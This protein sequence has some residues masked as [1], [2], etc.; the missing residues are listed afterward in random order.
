MQHKPLQHVLKSHFVLDPRRTDFIATFVLALIKVRTVNLTQISTA[1]NGLVQPTSN[2]RRSKRF[3]E[4]N[5][6]Q[7]LIAKFVLSFIDDPKLVLTMDRTNWKFGRIS[8]NFLVIGIAFGGIA[9]PV[10]WKNLGKDGNSNQ[11]ERATLLE[12]LLKVIPAHRILALTADREFIGCDW[13]KAL[14]AQEVNPVIRLKS[15]AMI[16]HRGI[17]APASVWFNRLKSG[18]VLELTKARVMGV[19]VFVLA[20]LTPEG[21]F[22]ILATRKRPA[23]AL[24]VYAQRWEIETLF[25]AFKTRG[26]NLEDTHVTHVERSER[27]FGLLVVALIWVVLTGEFVSSRKRL[28]LKNHGWSERSVFRVGLDCLRQI[29]LS[30][31][32]GKLVLDDV[33]PLLS[34]S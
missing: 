17:R 4:Y 11:A 12:K 2:A 24:V 14:F 23:Q 27:L 30:G 25:A 18:E 28:R 33:V 5:L 21:E 6:C 19:R 7:E 13:F 15:D 20:T 9:I 16:Q 10:A 8:I 29:L 31:C 26:F 3:L 1:L 22:L 32:S 34:S